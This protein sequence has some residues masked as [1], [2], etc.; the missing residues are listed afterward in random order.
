M[1]TPEEPSQEKE[2]MPNEKKPDP[3]NKF[4]QNLK[5]KVQQ[6]KERDEIAKKLDEDLQL[7]KVKIA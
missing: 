4:I 3:V 5:T 1:Q 6:D 7:Q 2:E